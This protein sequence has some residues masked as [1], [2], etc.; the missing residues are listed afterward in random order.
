MKVNQLLELPIFLHFINR[1]AADSASRARNEVEDLKIILTLMI[2]H[3]GG[4]SVNI[5]Q[6]L[7][8]TYG[9]HNLIGFL[10]VLFRRGILE[11][12]SSDASFDRFIVERQR[13][14]GHIPERYPM[15]FA[16]DKKLQLFDISR[17]NSFSMTRV[18][19]AS[20]LNLD[21][22]QLRLFAPLSTLRD[23]DLLVSNLDGI[24]ETI[25]KNPDAGITRDSIARI[26][27][28]A[29]ISQSEWP[30]IGRVFSAMYVEEYRN[31]N[32]QRISTGVTHDAY[33]DDL[34]YFPN[35]DY[36]ILR[37]IIDEIFGRGAFSQH[38][39]TDLLTDLYCSSTHQDFVAALQSFLL[40]SYD[41]FLL[42]RNLITVNPDTAP[43]IRKAF[44]HE[45]SRADISSTVQRIRDG[46]RAAIGLDTALCALIEVAQAAG[47]RSPI[48]LDAWSKAYGAKDMKRFIVMTATDRE[49]VA[50]RDAALEAGFSQVGTLQVGQQL[51]RVFRFGSQ[52]EVVRV[53]SSMGSF[54]AGGSGATAVDVIRAVRPDFVISA[55]ICFGLKPDKQRLGD[56]LVAG[57]V[58]DYDTEKVSEKVPGGIIKRGERTASSVLLMSA[59]REVGEGGRFEGRS[60]HF[61]SV[62]SGQ[63]LVDDR[64]LVARL[65]AEYPE[66]LGGEMEG[67][68]IVA[69]AEREKVDWLLIKGVCD[70][71][72][73]K[74]DKMQRLASQNAMSFTFAVVKLLINTRKLE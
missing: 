19:R 26:L 41:T 47:K 69:A 49:D 21:S 39:E 29:Q 51:C 8:Y 59:A 44:V 60:V 54:G 34:E 27:G 5:S 32:L 57:H 9:R 1:E 65:V 17:P 45:L 2:S 35:Y 46:T 20:L 62:L 74:D 70:W 12:T 43:S 31:R 73:D 7:E 53:R 40:A 63:K 6:L 55:G 10:E 15:Y 61:G 36:P 13:L 42:T 37:W 23:R 16:D 30:A 22:Q 68:G 71:G 48:F 33:L 38:R 28:P 66:A 4:L 3:S 52:F 14:Y 67:N 56:I 24:K 11:T 72:F 18:L 25:F 50:F 58:V 64:E